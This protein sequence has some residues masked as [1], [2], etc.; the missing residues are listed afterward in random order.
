LK[1]VFI[2]RQKSEFTID[3]KDFLSYHCVMNSKVKFLQIMLSDLVSH[4]DTLEIELNRVLND[5]TQPTTHKKI[6]FDKI[7]G[8]ISE[9][10]NKIQMLSEY[11]G[12]LNSEEN[13]NNE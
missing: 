10:N 6:D 8:E 9:N 5:D 4:R 13:N 7:L 2:L 3:F 11:M 1:K 12:S